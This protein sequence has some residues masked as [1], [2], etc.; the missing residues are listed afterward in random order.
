MRPTG[1]ST[2]TPAIPAGTTRRRASTTRIFCGARA[3]RARRASTN[4]AADHG[5]AVEEDDR[6]RLP[7]FGSGA[8]R[9]P[10]VAIS[11]AY[12]RRCVNWPH[13]STFT[14]TASL[15][16]NARGHSSGLA[17]RHGNRARDRFWKPER[18]QVRLL[19]RES[20]MLCV[21]RL[22]D[23]KCAGDRVVAGSASGLVARMQP[24]AEAPRIG[25]RLLPPALP[26]PFASRRL[27]I[28]FREKIISPGA[29]G[30]E[31]IALLL[32]GPK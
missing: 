31:G 27:A 3:A 21:H 19:D 22:Q 15:S 2:T 11:A 7:N 32:W 29:I 25:R 12:S 28:P 17:R 8:Q 4:A 10:A 9:A 30:R 13:L 24:W 18:R 26:H 16:K 6:K 23:G 1:R 5:G 14:T 20:R